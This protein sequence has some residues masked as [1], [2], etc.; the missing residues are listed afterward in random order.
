MSQTHIDLAFADGTYRFA[1]YLPQLHELQKTCGIGIGGLYGRVLQGRVAG[2]ITV[3]HPAYGQ[4]HIDDLVETVRQGLIGG[5]EGYVGEGD[6]RRDVKVSALRA[7]EL[8]ETYLLPMPLVDQWSLAAAILYAKVEGYEPPP[9]DGED[10][11]KVTK[12][13]KST[14]RKKGGSTTPE[15]SP[16]A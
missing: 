3:G 15:R 10:K 1:L 2:D 5:G 13:P 4:Y 12:P 14:G 9:D 11:K 7:N 6:N 16:T 8:V